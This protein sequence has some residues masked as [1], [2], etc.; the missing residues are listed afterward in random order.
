M[1]A[2]K[3][4]WVIAN[5]KTNY[6]IAAFSGLLLGAISYFDPSRFNILLTAFYVLMFLANGYLC[7]RR[8]H[9]T[10]VNIWTL[11]VVVG[12]GVTFYFWF[13][14]GIDEPIVLI[15]LPIIFVGPRTQRVIRPAHYVDQVE[16]LLQPV[17]GSV[18]LKGERFATEEIRQIAIA[19]LDRHTAIVQFP[20]TKGCPEYRFPRSQIDT[21]RALAKQNFCHAKLTT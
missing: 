17:A 11:L 13:S 15:F 5:P 8:V 9:T 21:A 12:V 1:D 3:Q 10:L 20:L 19:E 2:A 18:Y 14:R 6:L 16:T 4:Q 7:Q